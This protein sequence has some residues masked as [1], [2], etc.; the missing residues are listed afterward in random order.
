MDCYIYYKSAANNCQHILACAAQLQQLLVL[1]RVEAFRLQQRP[2]KPISGDVV[3]WME[4]YRDIPPDF[5][6]ILAQV[7]A[8]TSMQEWIIGE[9][10]MEYFI[11]VE[12]LN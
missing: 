5:E 4:I 3:T 1:Q 6:T 9:R 11:D 8:Q 2:V 12:L 7:L 10:R